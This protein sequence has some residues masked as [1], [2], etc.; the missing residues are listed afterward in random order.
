MSSVSMKDLLEAGI[1]FGHQT[2]R[3]HPKMKRYIYGQRN[4]IYIIDLQQT[5]SQLRRACNVVRLVAAQGGKVLFV[6]TKRQA[7]EPIATEAQRCGMYYVNSRWLGGTLTNWQTIRQSIQTLAR[8]EELEET[9]KIDAY[10]KKEIVKMRKHR[11]KLEGTLSGIKKMGGTP[12]LMFV[13]DA[14]REAIAIKEAERLGIPC[15]GIVDTNCDPDAVPLPIPG[16]DDAIRAISLFCKAIADSVIEGRSEFEKKQAEE[17]ER[18]QARQ[19]EQ[20]T[21]LQEEED[22]SPIPVS[23]PAVAEALVEEE[24]DEVAVVEASE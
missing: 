13:V 16:N 21:V 22:A 5:M 17:F 8:L 11:E 24:S 20:E 1:H 19:K 12:D 2:R 18:D 23:R 10:K 15:I 4:D 7:Q 9:G 14:K 6:G 3:W